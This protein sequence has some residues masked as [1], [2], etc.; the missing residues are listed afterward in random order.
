MRGFGAGDPDET[1]GSVMHSKSLTLRPTSMLVALSGALAALVLA[2]A[3]ALPPAAAQ[4]SRID[5]D[6]SI[7]L[8]VGQVLA[9]AWDG[10]RFWAL[11][12]ER[13]ELVGVDPETGKEVRRLPA[14]AA[15]PKSITFG[16][17]YL[18]LADEEP[19]QLRA[20][21]L[22]TGE[23]VR[24][25]RMQVPAEKG[26]KSIEG[27][28]WDTGRGM[29]WAAYA[30]GFSST[31]N[32]IDPQTG[33]IVQSVFADCNPRG[34]AADG[35]NLYTICYNGPDLPAK[36]DRR[37]VLGSE[38]DMLGSRVFLGDIEGK[39]PKGLLFD[40]TTLWYADGATKRMHRLSPAGLQRQ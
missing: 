12:G 20:I 31:L 22:A 36:I 30:A 14:A 24:S 11:D 38:R 34:V 40:G 32:R 1:I 9:L 37:R 39:D 17:G 6:R 25:L 35:T 16:G 18:W 19:L 4:Q 2:L 8:P 26:F 15:Q 21:D 10:N 23:V 33:R 29:I 3:A 13:R 7:P 5:Q 27:I 28:A